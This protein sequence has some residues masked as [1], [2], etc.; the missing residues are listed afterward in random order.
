MR[1]LFGGKDKIAFKN[2]IIAKHLAVN[3]GLVCGSLL[4]KER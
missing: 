1:N 3:N 4:E 2:S